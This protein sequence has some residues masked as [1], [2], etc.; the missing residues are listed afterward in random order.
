MAIRPHPQISLL[1]LA[2]YL[3]AS[4]ARRRVIINNHAEPPEEIVPQYRRARP[5]GRRFLLSGGEDPG[6]I[7]RAIESIERTDPTSDWHERDL[8]N[9]AEALKRL[10]A[11][12]GINLGERVLQT[13][14]HGRMKLGGVRIS[15]RPTVAVYRGGQVGA[16]KLFFRKGRSL[17][18]EEAKHAATLLRVY[19]EERM[20]RLPQ[21]VDPRLC[22]IVDVWQ[23]S[24]HSAPK[25]FKRRM[26]NALASCQ[27]IALMWP[28]RE[29][30]EIGI[31]PGDYVPPMH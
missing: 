24:V 6:I 3:E 19:V 28:R 23:G 21:T 14:H 7:K 30:V 11:L 15:V 5:A 31:E 4:A 13:R 25:A 16:V 22:Q 1:S 27:E 12:D 20:E 17:S 18:E 10:L 9:S 26:R 2:E 29:R 8:A